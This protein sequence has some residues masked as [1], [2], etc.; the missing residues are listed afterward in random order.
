MTREEKL[1]KLNSIRVVVTDI[2]ATFDMGL[3]FT[4]MTSK[5]VTTQLGEV[6]EWPCFVFNNEDEQMRQVVDALRT[7]E[8][9]TDDEI[10]NSL[11]GETL[12]TFYDL[13]NGDVRITDEDRISDILHEI[14]NNLKGLQGIGDK[15]YA[16]VS[17]ASWNWVIKFFATEEE[18]AD[19]FVE[20]FGTA[21]DSY[22]SMSD[23][24]LDEY[25]D[26]AEEAEFYSLPLNEI[27]FPEE[28]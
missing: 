25:C 9:I 23:D 8:E 20:V 5:G 17:L 11:L 27:G 3:E 19:Y 16:Y 2:I 18:L 24:E 14:R 15:L 7:G 22:E 26:W 6:F 28:E 12:T 21:E 1:A 4:T 10:L 13:F